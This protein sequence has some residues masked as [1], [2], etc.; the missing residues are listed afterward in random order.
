M[1]LATTVTLFVGTV[2][3]LANFA[4]A[5]E[6][7]ISV[8]SSAP[9][10][11]PASAQTATQT[12]TTKPAKKIETTPAYGIAAIISRSIS[13]IDHQDG[14]KSDSADILLSPSVKFS[15]GRLYA[16][17]T[18]SQDLRDEYAE[19]DIGDIPVNF[20]LKPSTFNWV[21]GY[22]TSVSYLLT[23]VA[24]ASKT[25]TKK[26]QLQTAISGRIGLAF[27][28]KDGGFFAATTLSAGRNFHAYEEDINGNV[29]NQYS[30][31]QQLKLGYTLD[32]WTISADYTHKTRWTY[33]G[34]VKASFELTEELEYTI[35]KNYAVAVGHT[36]SGS[37]LKPNGTDS[38]IDVFN[39]NN[40]VVYMSLSLSYM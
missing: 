35:N 13:L 33:R 22:E 27:E 25:S 11:A 20:M 32:N 10:A 7:T 19:N 5:E 28:P 12:L 36:N 30:S 15:T 9:A 21:N 38:N 40:S 26:D 24:P 2:L 37:A 16:F 6:T 34:N 39:E 29:L 3:F 4:F 18:Y 8:A 1:K 14:S 23:A 17:L 31:N